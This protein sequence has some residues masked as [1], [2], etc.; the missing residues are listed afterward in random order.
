V[1]VQERER[2]AILQEVE[3]RHRNFNADRALVAIRQAVAAR[4]ELE[5]H[6]IAL[7]KAGT[8]PKTSSGKTRRSACR[9]LLF[10]GRMDVLARW[11]AEEHDVGPV[12]EEE[13]NRPAPRKITAS[14]AEAWLVQR[15]A[16]R[17]HLP[18]PQVHVTTPFTDF[19]MSSVDVVEIA[20]DLESWIGRRLSPTA[21]YNYP[22]V[23]A[24]AR[25]L[26][27]SQPDSAPP[28]EDRPETGPIESEPLRA[29]VLQESDSFAGEVRGMTDAEMEAFIANEMASFDPKA[30]G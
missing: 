16:A 23:A 17:L 24:L 19:G 30:V 4:H 7:V 11:R 22:T 10:S 5:V 8:I 9:E 1:E 28:Q 27:S 2:L 26:A 13:W 14:E 12:T 25:W 20:A 21:I 6:E 3:P 15:I 29:S 18:Q